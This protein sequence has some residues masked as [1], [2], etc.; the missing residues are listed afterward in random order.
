MVRC[1]S[2][3]FHWSML[4]QPTFSI[5]WISK[6]MKHQPDQFT[7]WCRCVDR[8]R[9]LTHH[10]S[11]TIAIPKTPGQTYT[12]NLQ[13]SQVIHRRHKCSGDGDDSI[14][15]NLLY[16]HLLTSLWCWWNIT[17]ATIRISSRSEQEECDCAR[18]W[19]GS[20]QIHT[21][22]HSCKWFAPVKEGG[23]K[24]EKMLKLWKELYSKC[25][26]GDK[27]RTFTG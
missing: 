20:T 12:Y 22:A 8:S 11:L 27:D 1:A 5:N 13:L 14:E 10:T 6:I 26:C 7:D 2:T 4:F 23:R 21:H 17:V 15:N 18:Y 9:R 19:K 16:K 3:Y 24:R 25:M